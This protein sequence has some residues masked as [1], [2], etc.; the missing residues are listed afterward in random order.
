MITKKGRASAQI[1][2]TLDWFPN[3]VIKGNYG[4]INKVP[5]NCLISTNLVFIR[6]SSQASRGG[7]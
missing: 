2:I 4:N 1:S 5:T 7:L 6:E 3:S